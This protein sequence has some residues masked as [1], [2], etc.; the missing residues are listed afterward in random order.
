MEDYCERI[1][2]NSNE[3]S[4]QAFESLEATIL[5]QMSHIALSFD[6]FI[7]LQSRE[8]VRM[9]KV[10][11]G[12]RIEL[13]NIILSN[14]LCICFYILLLFTYQ[15]HLLK[16]NSD[17]L[18]KLCILNLIYK[19]IVNYH[20]EISKIVKLFCVYK[21]KCRKNAEVSKKGHLIVP[22]TQRI[23]LKVNQMYE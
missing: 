2:G 15:V 16:E 5:Q 9:I 19:Y 23:L 14:L 8:R 20:C 22:T 10:F 17:A 7:H 6:E 1:L 21:S 4:Y 11:R 3:V 13:C 18:V 12:V